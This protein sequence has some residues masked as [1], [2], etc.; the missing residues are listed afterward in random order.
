MM[1]LDGKKLNGDAAIKA[2][3]AAERKVVKIV[4]CDNRHT[5]D[6]FYLIDGTWYVYEDHDC[7]AYL[8]EADAP[9]D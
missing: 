2:M 9:E 5:I 4:E 1:Y 7:W 6:Y 3:A 8:Y